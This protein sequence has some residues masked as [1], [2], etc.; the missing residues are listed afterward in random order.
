MAD[1]PFSWVKDPATRA[2]L[3]YDLAR[4]L[5]DVEELEGSEG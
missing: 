4:E 5:M 2:D 3:Q 1:F